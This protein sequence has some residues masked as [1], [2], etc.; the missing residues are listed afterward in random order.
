MVGCPKMRDESLN[1]RLVPKLWS[2]KNLIVCGKRDEKWMKIMNTKPKWGDTPMILFVTLIKSIQITHNTNDSQ[3]LDKHA[4]TKVFLCKDPKSSA[5]KGKPKF[6]FKRKG[7]K[8]RL[9]TTSITLWT[10]N[11][12]YGLNEGQTQ[13]KRK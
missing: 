3:Y 12:E 5:L 2:P 13:H 7:H 6:S 8:Q 9:A 1:S 11:K 4:I 10:C